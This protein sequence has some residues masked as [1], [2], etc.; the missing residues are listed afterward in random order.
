MKFTL[1]KV[2]KLA[3]KKKV[4]YLIVLIAAAAIL[5][6][7]FVPSKEKQAPTSTETSTVAQEVNLEARLKD[8]LSSVE[9]AGKVEVVINYES[10]P[11]LV[12]A[13]TGDV[14]T[15]D[16]R[17]GENTSNSTSER[18]E[19]ATVG[20]GSQAV[21]IKENQPNVRGVVIVAEGAGNIGVRMSLLSAVRTLLNIPS[22]KIEILKM[23][24]SA[25]N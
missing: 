16:R 14:K 24:D 23:S 18:K 11:E 7:Y 8:I 3:A 25:G 20:G 22:E 1:E 17:D 5:T 9:G 12:P 2:K 13:L 4:Q 21:I 6:I 10:T 15:E 19:L